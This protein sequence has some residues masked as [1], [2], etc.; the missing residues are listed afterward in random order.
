MRILFLD[1]DGV[2]NSRRSSLY[3]QQDVDG[4]LVIRDG[5]PFADLDWVA[6]NMIKFLCTK[7]QVKLVLSSSW[8]ETWDL[9]TLGQKLG[10]EFYDATDTGCGTRGEQIQRWLDTHPEVTEYAIVDDNSGMLQSQKDHFV[11]TDFDEGLTYA[12]WKRLRDILD[13]RLGGVQRN[14]LM[15]DLEN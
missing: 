11:Q 13:G 9:G 15:W 3:Y 2:L 12:D 10:L 6:V 5:N 4:L 14:S 8:R 7:Q 1:I